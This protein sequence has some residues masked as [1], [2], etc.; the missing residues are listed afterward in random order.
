MI[1]VINIKLTPDQAVTKT[2]ENDCLKIELARRLK[3]S[4]NSITK[5]IIKR[6]A[7]DAR[8]QDNI[9]FV[10]SLECSVEN[11]KEILRKHYRGVEKVVDR[12]MQSVV[13]GI[14]KLGNRPLIIGAG[15]S[16][17]F[18][19]LVLAKNN[20]RPLVIDR[21][22][23]V[24]KRIDNYHAFLKTREFNEDASLVYGEG[25]AGTYSDG[26]LTTLIN[27]QRCDEVLR[28]LI[29]NGADPAIAYYAKP[30]VGTDKLR[31]IIA[32][33]SRQ[34]ESFGGEIRFNQKAE[35]FLIKEG[36]LFGVV[37][38][39]GEV[40]DTD[41]C[42][43]GSGH[44]A[45]D[46]I[47]ALVC[48]G[49][50]VS[51]KPFSIG[52]R[53][54]HPQS[55]INEAQ[56]GRFAGHPALKAAEYKLVYHGEDSRSCYTFCMCPGGHVVCSAS[57]NGGLVTNGMSFSDRGAQNANSALLVSVRPGDYGSS[58][59]LA[60][61]RFQRDLE[62]EAYRL[63]GKNYNA[64]IQ[65]LGD[66]LAGRDSKALG[67]II[68]SYLPGTTFS[69]LDKYLPW[70]VTSTI[71]KAIPDFDRK[72]RGFA[73]DEAVLTA[74][75]SRSSSPVRIDRNQ[76]HQANI[77]GLYPMGEG[78]GY[79]GGIMSSAVDGIKTAEKIISKYQPFK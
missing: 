71:K 34:I 27:D 54:E 75:E 45:R 66:F 7:L 55:L 48:E 21:G 41:V 38:S 64:P 74:I 61:F 73:M 59:P 11:E 36:R 76:D 15:P 77:E 50:Y 5:L 32:S 72:I 4:H 24:K 16:G 6:K 35:R 28:A 8:N 1:S 46:T 57:G 65:L 2:V 47:E 9:H 37:L 18:A 26:K 49:L 56:Y 30:H 33:L 51:Q 70:Y 42:L 31:G 53:I 19:A 68:P 29:E 67:S 78:S 10:Y 52:L 40:I 20:Y 12:K 43:L 22:C 62:E 69:R 17:L 25:G 39:T 60:G 44:S 63:G 79:A 58:D 3:L 14:E 13:S 23:E